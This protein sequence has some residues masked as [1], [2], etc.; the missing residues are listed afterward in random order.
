MVFAQVLGRGRATV[1]QCCQTITDKFASI[2]KDILKKV[3]IV[4]APAGPTTTTMNGS[5]VGPTTP[6]MSESSVG[7]TTTM[8]EA[9]LH[10]QEEVDGQ[11]VDILVVGTMVSIALVCICCAGFF[12]ADRT[13]RSGNRFEHRPCGPDHRPGAKQ[14]IPFF[15]CPIKRCTEHMAT[16]R[17][18]AM[19]LH[20]TLQAAG[21]TGLFDV[22]NLEEMSEA[23]LVRQLHRFVSRPQRPPRRRLMSWHRRSVSTSL[24]S[25][26]L[27]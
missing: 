1:F 10:V 24:G 9:S 19:L 21:Y 26:A 13:A 5:P 20:T 23:A 22:D 18:T 2:A 27:S 3:V 4:V 25:V 15:C 7:P 11:G 16:V 14:T 8:N 17:L 12:I 6:M